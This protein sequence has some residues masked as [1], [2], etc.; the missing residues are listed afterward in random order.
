[1]PRMFHDVRIDTAQL[2]FSSLRQ[3]PLRAMLQGA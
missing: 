2:S 1:M 3:S